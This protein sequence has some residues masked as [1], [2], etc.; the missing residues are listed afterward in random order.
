MG[1]WREIVHCDRQQIRK[2]GQWEDGETNKHVDGT[3]LDVLQTVAADAGEDG[4]Y[5]D[6]L[7]DKELSPIRLHIF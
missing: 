2:V 1:K 5:D 7:G 4:D 3:G 6:D